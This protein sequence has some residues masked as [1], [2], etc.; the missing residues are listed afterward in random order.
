M[1]LNSTISSCKDCDKREVGC[2]STCD[3]YIKAKEEFEESK[4]KFA[5]YK[6]ETYS[7]REG[8]FLGDGGH[9]KQGRIKKGWKGKK[10]KF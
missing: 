4:R 5:I 3:K 7:I 2:H 9:L 8:D 1:N 6:K 10:K